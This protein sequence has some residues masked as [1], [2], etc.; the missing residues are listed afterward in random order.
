MVAL[1]LYFSYCSCG[2]AIN[3]YA[4]AMVLAFT[5]IRSYNICQGFKDHVIIDRWSRENRCFRSLVSWG[6]RGFIM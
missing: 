1:F 2:N 5:S 4:P 3:A 6:D